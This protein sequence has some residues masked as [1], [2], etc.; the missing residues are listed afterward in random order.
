MFFRL[1][2]SLDVFLQFPRNKSIAVHAEVCAFSG[3]I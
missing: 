3:S 2:D 1:F